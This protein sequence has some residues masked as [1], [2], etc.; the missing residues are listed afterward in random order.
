MEH[1]V[2]LDSL[3]GKGRGVLFRAL[4]GLLFTTPVQK[5]LALHLL[6][7]IYRQVLESVTILLYES[8]WVLATGSLEAQQ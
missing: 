6:V 1:K 3:T 4:S 8:I 2:A 5:G 7:W